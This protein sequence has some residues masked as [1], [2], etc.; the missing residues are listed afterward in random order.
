MNTLFFTFKCGYNK[1]VGRLFNTKENLVLNNLKANPSVAIEY[2]NKLKIPFDTDNS[3]RYS[4]SKSGRISVENDCYGYEVK[5]GYFGGPL[6]DCYPSR[7]GL[8]DKNAKL[9][10]QSI[11]SNVPGTIYYEEKYHKD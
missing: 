10:Y 4:M 8:S 6:L 7:Y 3:C 11:L 1:T 5:I 9:L 2:F